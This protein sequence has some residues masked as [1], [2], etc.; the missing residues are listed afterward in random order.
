M[1]SKQIGNDSGMLGK[2]KNK[3]P[4]NRVGAFPDNLFQNI[5][6]LNHSVTM[7]FFFC[8]RDTEEYCHPGSEK[9]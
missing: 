5:L 8:S 3:K 4:S 2:E 1:P 7:Y 6:K 9:E